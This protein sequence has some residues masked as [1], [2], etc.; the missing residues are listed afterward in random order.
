MLKEVPEDTRTEYAEK[1]NEYVV[2]FHSMRVESKRREKQ[3]KK[4]EKKYKNIY[5]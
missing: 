4:E 3:L 5:L 2:E 1:V